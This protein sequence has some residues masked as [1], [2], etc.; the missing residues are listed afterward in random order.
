MRRKGRREERGVRT[1][2]GRRE[3]RNDTCVY[4]YMYI[5]VP[6]QQMAKL[7]LAKAVPTPH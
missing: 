2:G 5:K 4:M 6:C 7:A 1:I 3:M